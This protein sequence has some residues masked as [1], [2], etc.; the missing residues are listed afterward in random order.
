MG[1]LF[2]IGQHRLLCGDSTKTDT[3]ARLFGDQLA[4]LVVTDPPYNVALGCETPEQAKARNRR[5]DGKVIQ[6]DKMS[7]EDFY[8]FLY[9]FYTALGTYTKAGGCWYIWFAG[10]S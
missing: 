5:T 6:N 8:Q 9:D 4:D 1:D 2:E 10:I 3:F 7:N